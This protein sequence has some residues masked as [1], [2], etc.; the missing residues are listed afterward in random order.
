[1][2]AVAT[3]GLAPLRIHDLRHTTA[4]LDIAAGRGEDVADRLDALARGAT[5]ERI[6]AAVRLDARD[7]RGME[8]ESTTR[9]PTE[10]H[11]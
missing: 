8:L 7:F 6:P 5:A 11:R 2:R 4:S 9:K 3:A 10:N 1:M